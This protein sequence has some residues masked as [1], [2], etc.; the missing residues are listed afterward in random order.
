MT[1]HWTIGVD[2]GGTTIK[3]GLVDARGRVGR[4]LTLST[5]RYGR[6]DR[7]ISGI[8]HAVRRLA[9]A[10]G[11]R[12]S[13]L[14]GVGIGAPGSVDVARGVVHSCVNVPGWRRVALR[15]RLERCLHRPVVVD[16]DVHCFTLGEWRFGAGRGS[17]DLIGLT[18]GTGVGGGL[19]LAGHLYRGT[20]GSAGEIGHMVID[21]S[22]PRCG[23]GRRGCL[24]AHVGTRAIVAQARA[25]MRRQAGPL[26][27]LA[28]AAHGRI[29][30]ELI[31]RAA[32]AGDRG[33]RQLWDAFGHRLGIGL[34]NLVNLVN[35]Q[36]IVI[37]GGVTGSW[38]LFAP[39]M[40]RAIRENALRAPAHAV[41]VVRA[42]LADQAGIV[43]AAVLVWERNQSY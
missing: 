22:G 11:V 30:P 23:C 43:G 6:P 35:P 21:S 19:L 31:G 26:R 40:I 25:L 34:A 27:R 13:A 41:Q 24:E 39:R 12:V 28:Q 32:R 9:Q 36:R 5:A 2:F 38:P 18:L 3:C 4:A 7:F 8:D 17:H 14:R 15:A 1:R 37:G 16:N 42:E 33:A 29:S 20:I 10:A